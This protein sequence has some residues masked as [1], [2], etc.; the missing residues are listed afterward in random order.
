MT[1]DEKYNGYNNYETWLVALWIDNDE[2][3]QEEVRGIAR[4][5]TQI[6]TL[7]DELKNYVDEWPEISEATEKC[8]IVSDLVRSALSEVDWYELAEMYAKEV[9]EEDEE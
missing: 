7:A 1:K 4:G 3:R 2:Y 5:Q 9:K 8:S 6:G